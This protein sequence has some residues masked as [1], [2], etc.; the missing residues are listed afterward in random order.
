MTPKPKPRTIAYIRVSTDEQDVNKQRLEILDYANRHRIN[1]DEFISIEISSRKTTKERRIDELMG[2][3]SA[4]DTLIVSE[5]SRIGRSI[6]EVIGLV[7]ALVD[8]KI[9][10]LAIK[11]NL[12]IKGS[13]DMTSKIV[14]TIFSLLAELE[15]DLIS[16]RTKAALAA[17]KQAGGPLGR[18]KGRLGKSKLD[19]HRDEIESLL[20]DKVSVAAIA[21]RFKTHRFNLLHY[22][23]SRDIKNPAAEDRKTNSLKKEINRG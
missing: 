13:Q 1:V 9:R 12:D 20:Q 22:I 21:R 15:R 4:G 3:L 8:R 17:V 7:N 14:V 16:S 18:P 11:Q 5:L 6:P 2:K 19:N 23:S 10:L